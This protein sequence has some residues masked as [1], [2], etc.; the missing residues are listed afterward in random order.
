MAS[1]KPV[2][3]DKAS[4]AV[5][6]LLD[7]VK[8]KAGRVPNIYAALANSPAALKGLLS[9]GEALNTGAFSSKEK[10]AV[11]L[12]IAQENDCRY[13]LAAHTAIAKMAGFSE[14]ETIQLRKARSEDAKLK[15]L[16][17]LAREI[18][19]TKGRPAE[20]Y[21]ADFYAAGYKE[22]DLAELIAHVALNIFT[23]YFNAVADPAVDFPAY[24]Q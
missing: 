2:E 5:K 18:V 24:Q 21:I 4:D 8:K 11:A 20:K 22:P 12:S 7:A 19:R 15:A 9:F 17:G 16:A 6:P 1:M 14:E 13:C 23:N 10:E 3:Y